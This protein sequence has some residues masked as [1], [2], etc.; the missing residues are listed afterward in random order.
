M[1]LFGI[2]I[3]CILL[4]K[5]ESSDYE[6]V[7][8]LHWKVFQVQV[9]VFFI[10][11]VC[12]TTLPQFRSFS[13][14]PSYARRSFRQS[15]NWVPGNINERRFAGLNEFPHKSRAYS[16]HVRFGWIT[17]TA[18]GRISISRLCLSQHLLYTS[19]VHI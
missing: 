2:R 4:L 6:V 13:C 10:L 15:F 8:T 16:Y 5:Y 18:S 3:C 7:D 9:V 19:H 17:E 14:F 12:L 11:S 1:N